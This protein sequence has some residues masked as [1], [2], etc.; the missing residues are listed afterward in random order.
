MPPGFRM[1]AEL[2]TQG[3]RPVYAAISSEERKRVGSSM[4]ARKEV[5]ISSPT[6]GMARSLR[7]SSMAWTMG[8]TASS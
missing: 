1:P 3:A 2:F 5:A 8:G 7:M 6:P 4:R